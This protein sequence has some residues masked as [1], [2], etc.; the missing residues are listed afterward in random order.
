MKMD[1]IMQFQTFRINFSIKAISWFNI[2]TTIFAFVENVE[3]NI[4]WQDLGVY[5]N[6]PMSHNRLQ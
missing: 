2:V 1:L 3:K 4:T 5:D 6:V